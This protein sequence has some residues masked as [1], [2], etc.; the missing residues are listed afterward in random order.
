[1]KFEKPIKG[2]MVTF[3][4]VDVYLMIKRWGRKEAMRKIA[5]ETFNISYIDKI[6]KIFKF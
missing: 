6:F 3:N 1:M 4:K 2:P 5:G